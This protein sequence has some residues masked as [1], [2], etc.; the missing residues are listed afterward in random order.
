MAA[1]APAGETASALNEACRAAVA[2]VRS[3]DAA[4]RADLARRLE[5]HAA[6][7]AADDGTGPFLAALAALVR[8]EPAGPLADGLDEPW[9]R[10]LLAVAADMGHE[11]AD[12]ERAWVAAL[13]AR[14]AQVLRRRD[15]PGAQ[16][17]AEQLAAALDSDDLEPGAA[18]YLRVLLGA[19]GGQ[20]V[21]LASLRLAEPYRSAYF[22]L[23]ALLRGEDPRSGLVE[24][25]RDNAVLVLRSGNPEARAALAASLADVEA[26]AAAGPQAELADFL[27]AV[28]EQVAGAAELP[29][30]ALSEPDLVAAWAAVVAAAGSRAP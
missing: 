14:V 2:A 1:G 10:G 26:D 8:G 27:R 21:R 25:V 7:L 3:G 30:P 28:R 18:A 12:A 11:P 19:L 24:R 15:R 17:L 5:A 29:A 4:E 22:S 23:Q 13:A 6:G 9:R 16:A 20:D